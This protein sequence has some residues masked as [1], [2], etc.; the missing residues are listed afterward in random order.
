MV[1]LLGNP[2]CGSTLQLELGFNWDVFC[3]FENRLRKL[4]EGEGAADAATEKNHRPDP[5]VIEQEAARRYAR[6]LRLMSEIARAR[7]SF[8]LVAF[9]P[10][11]WSK[12]KPTAGEAA[13]L[14]QWK[15][16]G[17]AVALAR[18]ESFVSDV[19]AQLDTAGVPWIDLNT[20]PGIYASS[21]EMFL[22]I[23]HLNAQGHE[24]VARAIES[25]LDRAAAHLSSSIGST[26]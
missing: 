3:T 2:R 9:Q 11:L 13:G 25:K 17:R 1:P 5:R 19:A 24:A 4:V 8:F 7:G 15:S 21:E 16:S 12:L 20:E 22:D 14:E 23:V 10:H 26:R 18:Y 6:N